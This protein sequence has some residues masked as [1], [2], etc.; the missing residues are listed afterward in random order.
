MD[1]PYCEALGIEVPVLEELIEHRQANTYS[2]LI[3][4]L[5]EHGGPLSLAEVAERFAEAGIAP[6]EWALDSLQRCRPARAPVYRDGELYALDPYDEQLDRWAFRLGL[7]PPKVQSPPLMPARM[8]TPPAPLP[9]PETPLS[10]EE[11]KQAWRD[12]NLYSNWSAQR[13]ALAVLD[14]HG[15][16]MAPEEVLAFTK[17]C[18]RWHLL[19]T[20]VA[21]Y[22]NRAA[23]IRVRDDG[24]WAIAPEDRS[25]KPLRSARS[26]VR[27]LLMRI[28]L[29]EAQRPDPAVTKARIR[30]ME[31]RRETHAAEL[32]RLSRVV[33]HGF[34]A[35]APKAL[36]LVDVGAR[37]LSTFIGP[38][39]DMARRKLAG[40]DVIAA[41]DVRALLRALDF[42]ENGRRRLAELGPPQKSK[43]LNKRGRILKITTDMLIR[44]SCGIGSPLGQKRKLQEY[45]RNGQTTRLRR[46]LEADAKSLFA[47]YEYGRL[48]GAV[49]L[50]WGFLD[51]MIPAPWVHW[52]EL[53]L[54]D[55]MRRAYEN[56]LALEAVIGSAPGWAEPWARAR[57][58]RVEKDPRGWGHML[59][60]DQGF[61]ID[62]REVQLARLVDTVG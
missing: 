55:M 51:E 26:A 8:E 36:V 16:P 29:R 33:L 42:L 60:D 61:P 17:G 9:G 54:G 43:R 19:S 4:A 25:E 53:R 57:L 7:R 56:N 14:A 3:V 2:L 20:R 32:A 23:A 10:I 24:S 46:R 49:R 13:V 5:L 27:T 6:A 15:R 48:H 50:R 58:C 62:E 34:P 45:L 37:R 52:D 30:E 44:G 11:L 38:E 39:L 22:W 28:R 41:V 12:A 35:K 47:L 21:Q 59:L 18:T 40:F 1:N 31:R